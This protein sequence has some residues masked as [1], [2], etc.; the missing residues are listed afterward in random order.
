MYN[1][2][3]SEAFHDGS[4]L[5]GTSKGMFMNN[6]KEEYMAMNKISHVDQTVGHCAPP[7]SQRSTGLEGMCSVSTTS[8]GNTEIADSNP[9]NL[10]I[11]SQR[12]TSEMYQEKTLIKIDVSSIQAIC[13]EDVKEIR[14]KI[15]QIFAPQ[16]VKMIC[17]RA[18]RVY[19]NGYCVFVLYCNKCKK[20]RPSYKSNKCYKKRSTGCQFM[21]K[22]TKHQNEKYRLTDGVF[23]HNHLLTTP[24]LD[25]MILNQIDQFDPTTI[26]PAYVRKY[27]NEKFNKDISYAQIAYELSKRKKK[28]K[29][30]T[31]NFTAQDLTTQEFPSEGKIFVQERNKNICNAMYFN[32][33]ICREVLL[34]H[35]VLNAL[36]LLGFDEK[37][38]MYLH[39]FVVLDNHQEEDYLWVLKTFLSQNKVVPRVTI[40][41]YYESLKNA[42]ELIL[43]GTKII[44]SPWSCKRL[45]KMYFQERDKD[46][47][48]NPCLVRQFK[49][50]SKMKQEYNT[51]VVADL[52]ETLCL[53]EEV[54]LEKCE[55][56]LIIKKILESYYH[57]KVSNN[58][59][60][61]FDDSI[62]AEQPEYSVQK[63]NDTEPQTENVVQNKT[64]L[65]PK[66]SNIAHQIVKDKD[67]E[68]EISDKSKHYDQQSVQTSSSKTHNALFS[69]FNCQML[70]S[71]KSGTKIPKGILQNEESNLKNS[72]TKFLLKS[73]SYGDLSEPEFRGGEVGSNENSSIL[74]GF[75]SM[76][77]PKMEVPPS[78]ETPRSMFQSMKSSIGKCSTKFLFPYNLNK[79]NTRQKDEEEGDSLLVNL[80]PE[81]LYLR[82]QSPV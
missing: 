14:E 19:A 22:F 13:F 32:D 64:D 65:N 28:V 21:L 55:T 54:N 24:V 30:E 9:K 27:I 48:F 10:N 4:N 66:K 31:Q 47:N 2:V 43:H 33:K 72:T 69:S 11:Q 42:C 62:Y 5:N 46:W 25:S 12:S 37:A 35:K 39:S 77:S 1:L 70:R 74:A 61:T 79:I 78:P 17:K 58:L 53:K 45:E 51:Q 20:R 29:K 18:E 3:P 7:M 81:E 8:Y 59:R 73:N 67:C 57:C 26:K 16:N 15:D 50:L 41:D 68:L 75:T 49:D 23:Q 56:P 36:L 34:I 40:I 60:P 63:N 38:N 6:I 52:L 80:D 82:K 44:V 71:P 76:N